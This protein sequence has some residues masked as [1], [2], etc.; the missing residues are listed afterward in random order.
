[1]GERNEGTSGR[2]A[3]LERK[4]RLLEEAVKGHEEELSA[5]I[6]VYI[7]RFGMARNRASI[8][9]LTEEV[10]QDTAEI[11]LRKLEEY[12]EGRKPV[13]WLLGITLNVI[14]HR[15]RDEVRRNRVYP[16]SN[17]VPQAHVPA[18]PPGQSAE[19]LTFDPAVESEEEILLNSMTADEV[20]SLV[21]ENDRQVLRLAYIEGLSG[22]ELAARLA[23]SEGVVH[24]RLSRA[25]TRAL[26]AYHGSSEQ[27]LR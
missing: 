10:L 4:W 14:R 23:I 26:K 20:L 7:W 12:D 18:R 9:A 24:T 27:G 5:G 1:M 15:L 16:S 3:N 17:R 19:K 2:D 25:R 11:A 13:P 21:G 22:R 8:E 6:R